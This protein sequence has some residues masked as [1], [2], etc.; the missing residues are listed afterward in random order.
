MH[1]VCEYSHCCLVPLT[2]ESHLYYWLITF[3]CFSLYLA[4]RDRTCW[5]LYIDR[6]DSTVPCRSRHRECRNQQAKH[7]HEWEHH[8][9]VDQQLHLVLLADLSFYP[10]PCKLSH[11]PQTLNRLQILESPL[12][13]HTASTHKLTLTMLISIVQGWLAKRRVHRCPKPPHSLH[14]IFVAPTEH[15]VDTECDATKGYKGQFGHATRQA[16]CRC[17]GF[18]LPCWIRS[19][20]LDLSDCILHSDLCGTKWIQAW[21]TCKV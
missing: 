4:S 19:W 9:R 16:I 15:T 18:H 7:R 10:D 1:F 12:L 17:F 3:I 11:Q 5:L 21:S 8:L 6:K 2:R 20:Q 14:H 13:H